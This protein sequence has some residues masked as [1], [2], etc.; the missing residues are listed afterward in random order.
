MDELDKQID[1]GKNYTIYIKESRTG[2]YVRGRAGKI[3]LA[4]FV[5][6]K[7]SKWLVNSIKKA[8]NAFTLIEKM[9]FKDGDAYDEFLALPTTLEKLEK[10]PDESKSFPIRIR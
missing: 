7:D 3:R 2:F 1:K 8:N 4:E 6:N 10:M 9:K 5:P